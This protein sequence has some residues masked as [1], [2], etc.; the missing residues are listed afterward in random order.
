MKK[1]IILILIFTIVLSCFISCSNSDLPKK[2]ELYQSA[3]GDVTAG[4]GFD[5]ETEYEYSYKPFTKSDVPNKEYIYDSKTYDLVYQ[6]SEQEHVLGFVVD[7]YKTE[8]RIKFSFREDTGELVGVDFMTQQ[9]YNGDQAVNE[10]KISEE[11]AIEY[12]KEIAKKHIG[13]I[14]GYTPM[15]EDTQ[16]NGNENYYT[17]SFVKFVDGYETADYI[18]IRISLN[19]ELGS[20]SLGA[21]GAFDNLKIEID[22]ERLNQSVAD[23][24]D[25][26]C[27]ERNYTLIDK[28]FGYQ[29]MHLVPNGDICI[30]TLVDVTYLNANGLEISTALCIETCVAKT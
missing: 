10:G 9:Y 16:K 29:R 24:L 14:D 21:I 18:S 1:L 12:S 15:L 2:M 3:I 22:K 4:G 26:I 6:R 5:V 17:V 27:E 7:I 19:G 20:I 25:K 30:Y 8:D 28:T 11:S 13:D 23:K